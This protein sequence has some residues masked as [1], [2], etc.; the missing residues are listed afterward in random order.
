MLLASYVQSLSYVIW[1]GP[2]DI[3]NLNTVFLPVLGIW[4]G[5]ILSQIVSPEVV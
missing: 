3:Q 2:L 4:I 5:S 1:N